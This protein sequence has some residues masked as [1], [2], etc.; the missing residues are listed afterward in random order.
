MPTVMAAVDTCLKACFVMNLG[1]CPGAKSSWLFLQ[2]IVYSI[3]TEN[4]DAGSKVLQL[5]ADCCKL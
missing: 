5:L 2:K 4:D 3:S 1:Y